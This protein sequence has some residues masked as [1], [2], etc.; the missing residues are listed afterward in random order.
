MTPE[1]FSERISEELSE[2]DPEQKTQKWIDVCLNI[3]AQGA[4]R[5][6]DE[7]NE[8]DITK[9]QDASFIVN[10][11]LPESKWLIRYL[12]S[13]GADVEVLAPQNIRN[14][15]RSELTEIISKY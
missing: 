15:I 5:V 11:S 7:F 3:S 4:Y 9:K 13:F 8:N 2:S 14:M 12:L 10:A 6:Y 1:S